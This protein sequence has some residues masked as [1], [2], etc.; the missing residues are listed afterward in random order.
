MITLNNI[1]NFLN[2]C[3]SEDRITTKMT[4][5]GLDIYRFDGEA[6]GD[7]LV[8][9]I[10]NKFNVMTAQGS[11][12]PFNEGDEDIFSD[13]FRHSTVAKFTMAILTN[14]KISIAE[15][16]SMTKKDLKFIDSVFI[17]NGCS[18]IEVKTCNGEIY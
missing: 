2:N 1:A 15:E 3:N 10:D 6:D 4:R 13:E 12:S 9:T 5:R 14:I 8:A 11:F 16:I 7:I 18:G 17:K